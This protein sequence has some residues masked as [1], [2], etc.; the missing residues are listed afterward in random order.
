MGN[1]SKQP[2]PLTVVFGRTLALWAAL[3]LL[4][5]L[6]LVAIYFPRNSDEP[7]TESEMRKTRDYYAAAYAAP[8]AGD[9]D[10]G[11]VEQYTRTAA[12]SA[13]HFGI[14]SRV[15]AFAA[16]NHLASKRVLEVGAGRGYLQ[17]V[18]DN[19]TG[20]DISPTVR[21]H[22]HKPF[23]VG[24]A[25]ALPFE[26]N[27]FDAVWTVW[28]LEHVPAPEQAL[29]EIRRVVKPGGHIF[30]LPAWD[31]MPWVAAGHNARPYNQLSLTGKLSKATIR[32]RTFFY[33]LSELLIRPIRYSAWQ[34]SGHPTT[35]R[36][37]KL[38]PNYNQ[39]WEPDSDAINN[40]SRHEL[41]LWFASRG[42]RLL[43]TTPTAFPDFRDELLIEVVK[44][45][46]STKPA[47]SSLNRST[48]SGS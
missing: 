47:L 27:S 16:A 2:S 45:L 5:C 41:S 20:L 36:Y 25:T 33:V 38:Q 34:L 40:L 18:V 39:Y 3:G 35:L 26:D 32:P 8:A 21:R 30:L 17:D 11:A 37:R 4:C 7:L 13:D 46:P 31:V 44:P 29:A 22:F 15:R 1:R 10:S 24:S 6:A 43:N 42:D 14:E 48:P 28:V 19:Y 23:V 9:S 12:A